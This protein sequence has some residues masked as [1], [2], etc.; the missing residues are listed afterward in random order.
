MYTALRFALFVV[1]WV[2][3]LVLGVG[4][5]LAAGVALVLSMPLS[6]VLLARPRA[7]LAGD[8]EA[9]INAHREARTALDDQLDPDR[10]DG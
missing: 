10:E 3:L 9:R 8:I 7:R 5:L 1:L 2:I 6:Y 4:G